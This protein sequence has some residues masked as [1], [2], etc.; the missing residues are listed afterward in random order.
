[1]TQLA[2]TLPVAC[3]RYRYNYLPANNKAEQRRDDCT[4]II[5]KE[6]RDFVHNR[7]RLFLFVK[8]IRTPDQPL[9]NGVIAVRL[10]HFFDAFGNALVS[11]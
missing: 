5:K 10:Q 7:A 1:V 3:R 4:A 11:S 9:V 8:R 2:S 6:L